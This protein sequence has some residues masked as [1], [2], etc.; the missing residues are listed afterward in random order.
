MP[1]R[2]ADRT[3]TTVLCRASLTEAKETLADA[4]IDCLVTEYDLSDGTGVDLI[5]Y[6]RE[7]APD[8]GC[9]LFT[10]ADREAI[11]AETGAGL[12]TEFVDK[13]SPDAAERLAQLVSVTGER[14]TQTSYPLPATEA[15]RLAVLDRLDF[16]S[17]SL[18]RAFERVTTLSAEHFGV[19]R[20]AINVIEEHTQEV[21]ACRGA[22]WTT[23]PREETICT[24]SIL[25]DD[26]TVIEDT[27]DDPR[28]E[29]SETLADLE[30][31]FYAGA[32]LTTD[33][34][35]SLGTVCIYDEE[36]RELAA[37]EQQYLQLLANETMHWIDLHSRLSGPGRKDSSEGRRR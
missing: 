36:S 3:D 15:D 28:F 29:E 31:R 19:D 20:S 22:E 10:D 7:A 34:G 21:L 17:P 2:V 13:E 27:A 25:N 23:I 12:V 5:R 32:P 4:E 24:Y 18:E 33:E 6:V 16:D 37:G 14:R 8:T 30:I 11:V 9:T 1:E 26:V 35:L